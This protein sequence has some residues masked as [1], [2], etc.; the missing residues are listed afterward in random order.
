MVELM[1]IKPLLNHVTS[2]GWEWHWFT[3]KVNKKPQCKQLKRYKHGV[4]REY[5]IGCPGFHFEWS[6]CGLYI[7]QVLKY[8]LQ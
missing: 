6:N 1:I 4:F 2:S 7:M 3:A 8:G 5:T